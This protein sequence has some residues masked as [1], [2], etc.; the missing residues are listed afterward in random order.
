MLVL[1][2]KISEAIRVGDD[3]RIQIMAVSMG[4]SVKIG[5]TAPPHVPVHREEVWLKIQQDRQAANNEVQP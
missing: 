1:G 3:V 4:G 2:R 5:I